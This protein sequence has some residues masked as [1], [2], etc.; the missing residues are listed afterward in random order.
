MADPSDNSVTVR[1]LESGQIQARWEP[2]AARLCVR[3]GG[4]EEVR[5][6]QARQAFPTTRPG[7]YV[8]I[9]DAQGTS[10]GILASLSDLE[11]DAREAIEAALRT[12]YLIPRIGR[13]L[14]MTESTTFVLQWRVQTDRGDRTFQTESA[15]EAVHYLG[16]D[17]IRVTD[18]A[19]NHYDVP[20]LSALDAESRAVL[21]RFL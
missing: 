7:A 17:R 18:L 6:V 19:G 16:P 4:G 11:A 12:R 20:S 9:I 2:G 1:W 14:E 8:E 10:L 3:I 15:R 5:D 13:I 21:G